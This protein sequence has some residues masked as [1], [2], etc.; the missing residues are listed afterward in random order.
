MWSR[1]RFLELVSGLPLVGGFIGAN[2]MPATAAAAPGAGRDYFRELGVRP[3]IN[4]A[5]TYTAMT[6][7]LMPPEVI[8]AI[9]YASR[10][11]VMLDEGKMSASGCVVADLNRDKR[12]DIICIGSSTA[13]LKWYEN[14]GP[15][16]TTS[17]GR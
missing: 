14:A 11:Y 16:A 1:R 13:N 15:A 5:G 6:A 17:A 9:T 3:F 12:V 2:T 10:H 8:E 4:A 7:S